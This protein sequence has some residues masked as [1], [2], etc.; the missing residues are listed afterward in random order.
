MKKQFLLILAII[1]SISPIFPQDE[2]DTY[3]EWVITVFLSSYLENSDNIPSFQE[4]YTDTLINPTYPVIFTLPDKINPAKIITID[5]YVKDYGNYPFD[6]FI[7]KAIPEY[8]KAMFVKNIPD[9]GL[10]NK[11]VINILPNPN[12]PSGLWRINKP[13]DFPNYYGFEELEWLVQDEWRCLLE[14][15]S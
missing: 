7:E 5:Q 14:F 12:E 15:Y 3:G 8:F 13:N 1:V 9:V 11:L 10:Y 6:K 2:A 4:Q